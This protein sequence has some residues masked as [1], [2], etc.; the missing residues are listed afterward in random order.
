MVGLCGIMSEP[1]FSPDGQFIVLTSRQITDPLTGELGEPS[2]CGLT[3]DGH[4]VFGEPNR[5]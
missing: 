2:L 5:G 1:S 4:F 3:M